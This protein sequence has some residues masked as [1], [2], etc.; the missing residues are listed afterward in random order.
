MMYLSTRGGA[1]ATAAEAVLNGLAPDG[2]LYVPETIPEAPA[3]LL[4]P[5]ASY[6]YQALAAEILSLFLPEFG[7]EALRRMCDE[8][9]ASFAAEVTPVSR[10][11][12]QTWLLE[13]YHGPTLAFKDVALQLLPRLIVRAAQLTGEK[14]VIHILT[15]TSGDT[16]KAALEGFRDVEGTACTVFYPKDGVSD[17][18]YRQMATSRGRNV[19]V[20][21][22]RGNFD[23]AQTGVK[24]LFADADFRSALDAA[25]RLPSSA[26]SINIG[27]LVPQIVYYF[28]AW[29]T[30][31]QRG[32]LKT[33]E[34]L[35]ICV[36]TGNFGDILA[37]WYARRMGLPIGRLVCASNRNRVLT[38]FISTGVYDIDRPFHKTIS[39][40]MDILISSNLERL[41]FELCGRDAAQVRAWMD[42]LRQERRF[43]LPQEQLSTLQAGFAAGTADD[44]QTRGSIRDTFERCGILTD[45][46]TAVGLSVLAQLRAAEGDARPTLVNATASPYKFVSDVSEAL[47][48]ET[49]GQVFDD[50][51]RLSARTRTTVPEAILALESADI[52]HTAVSTPADMGQ[53]VLKTVR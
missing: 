3:A 14:R 6:T 5:T 22:V 32:Q 18:Q 53:T 43:V 25:G 1:P 48:L 29:R 15:A 12:G 16:G 26:N 9:Y 33:G 24:R 35:D 8:A 23:D 21:A 27:R 42:G 40:S 47:G 11:D 41:L 52:L 7:A 38:D 44:A 19:Q 30:L 2:G 37:A 28:Y 45:P 13:L 10:L 51:R 49:S 17:L 50:A 46:H 36:P 34:R 31:C 39:P 4:D 20:I